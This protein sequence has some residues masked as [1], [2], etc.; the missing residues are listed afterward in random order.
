MRAGGGQGVENVPRNPRSRLSAS[1]SGNAAGAE[2]GSVVRVTSLRL[3]ARSL[4]AQFLLQPVTLPSDEPKI[5]LRAPGACPVELRAGD[6]SCKWQ[7]KV[8]L[9]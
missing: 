1:V 5:R 9:K 4:R 2:V 8:T 7:L 6:L 3:A